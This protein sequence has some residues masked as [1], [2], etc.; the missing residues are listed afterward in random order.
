VIAYPTR[1]RA[2]A[3][4]AALAALTVPATAQAREGFEADKDGLTAKLGDVEFN[5]GGRLHLDASVFDHGIDNG[6]D[7]DVRRARLEFSARLGDV[8]QVRVDREFAQADG[9]R[10]LWVGIKPVED[11][12]IRGGNQVVPFSMED[13]QSSNMMA[14]AERSLVNT[15]APA[16]GLGGSLRYTNDNFTLA[17]GYFTDA[18]DDEVGQS[19]VRGDG[20]SVRGTV[21]PIVKRKTYLHFGA[22]YERRSFD[23]LEPPRF[24]V[25]SASSLAP[26]LLRTGA[27]TGAT[28]LTAYN[29]E[30][31]Y[32]RGPV[33]VQA[34][35]VAAQVDRAGLSTLA[36]RRHPV[37][38]ATGQEWGGRT[39]SALQRG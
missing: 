5:L 22:A 37:G 15:F 25:I 12:E 17:G 19:R 27:L 30:F 6:T 34:Q 38:S 13:M 28:D 7:A 9:W 35:Y 29:G 24:T 18:L 2:L 32:A 39:G 10:N 23:A 26:S 14:L 16:F 8:V 20:F 33:Q 21:A 4:S 36:Q 1:R 31:A 11:L 3:V